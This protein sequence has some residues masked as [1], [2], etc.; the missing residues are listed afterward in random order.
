MADSEK[1]HPQ[2]KLGDTVRVKVPA[3]LVGTVTYVQYTPQGSGRALYQ[4]RVPMDPEP[5]LMLLE[6]DEMEAA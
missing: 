2:Y 1:Y 5:L 6:E 4:V 3:R